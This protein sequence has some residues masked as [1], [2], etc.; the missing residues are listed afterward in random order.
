ML[1]GKRWWLVVLLWLSLSAIGSNV[2]DLSADHMAIRQQVFVDF[3]LQQTQAVNAEILATRSKIQQLRAL[4]KLSKQDVLWLQQVAK[5]YGLIDF[6][7]QRRHDWQELLRRV[8]IIPNSLA[9][10]QAANESA[11]GTSRFARQGAN[12]FGLWCHVPGCGLVP[13][14]RAADK[15]HEVRIFADAYAA[16]AAY[17]HFLNT[18][19][20]FVKLRELRA[21]LRQEQILLTGHELA[22]G[23]AP[24]SALGRDYVN[25]IQAMISNYEFTQ[26]DGP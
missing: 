20:A 11:W 21:A 9:L 15:V 17:I 4:N 14:Q 13:R 18:H 23:L 10:A 19:P 26:F 12:Y 6:S 5:R 24:Y 2:S 25:I 7:Y 16:T 22:T 8:D 1:A 3:I